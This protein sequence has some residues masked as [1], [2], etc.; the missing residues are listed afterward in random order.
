MKQCVILGYV[1]LAVLILLAWFV[2]PTQWEPS[3]EAATQVRRWDGQVRWT[4][5]PQ[6]D[7]PVSKYRPSAQ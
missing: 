1:A 2:W 6:S 4:I 5:M 3:Y 7:P